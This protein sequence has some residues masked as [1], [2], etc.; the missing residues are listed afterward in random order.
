MATGIYEEAKRL[1]LEVIKPTASESMRLLP[2]ALLYGTGAFSLITYQT[3]MFF[4]FGVVVTSFVASNLLGS[5]M[6][7]FMPQNFPPA[8]ASDRCTPGLYSPTATR[9]A[10]ISELANPSGFPSS[11]MLILATVI[12]YCLGAIFQLSDVLNELGPDYQAKLPTALILSTILIVTLMTYLIANDCN[13]FLVLLSSVAI[14][15]VLG[16]ILSIS[17]PIIFGQ[18]AINLL[19]LPLFVRRDNAGQPLYICA[20]KL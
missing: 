6:T 7:T 1:F 20:P 3:P 14:G 13:G 17:I 16:A 4:L 2:D 9:M 15:S 10:L 11:P 18:E 12:S 5:L 8:K 19:G